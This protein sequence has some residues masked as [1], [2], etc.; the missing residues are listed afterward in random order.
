VRRPRP[1]L[2]ALAA[3]AL[4]AGS[5]VYLMTYGSGCGGECGPMRPARG[6]VV[7]FAAAGAGLGAGLGWALGPRQ[8]RRI[9][10]RRSR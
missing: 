10:L 7:T 5:V 9:P 6:F 8:W 1:A 4:A 3:G 2:L